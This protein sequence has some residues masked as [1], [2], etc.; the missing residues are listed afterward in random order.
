MW[1]IPNYVWVV[2]GLLILCIFFFTSTV[3]R[4][5]RR[6]GPH[7]ALL[8]Y[9]FRGTRVVKGGGTVVF[10]L[11]EECRCL[12]LEL[13]SFDVA[14]QQDLYTKQGVA[15]TV[16]AV[17]QIK[18]K[19]DPESI[20]TASE[21]FLTKTSEMRESLIRLVMEGHLRGIIGQ[22]T[23]EQIVKEPE[24]VA[25]RMRSTCADD[26][27]KM[28]LEVISF[29]IKEVR[30]KNEYISNMG[31]PDVARIK[32]DADVATA[33]AERDTAIKRAVAQ[34]ES[35]VAKAQADQERVL[36]ETL[37]LAKQAESERDLEIKRATYLEGVKRQQAQ[38]DKAYDIQ[39]NIMQQQLVVEQVKVQQVE[40]EHQI[41]VQEAEILRREKELI[42]TV[43][44]EAEIERQ[45]IETMANAEKQRLIMEA[46]GK[47][48]AVREQGG[49]EAEIILKKGEA[50]ARAM[51][52]KAEAFQE[53]NQA[54][55]IDK[56]LTGLPEIVRALAAPLANVDKITI[57]STGDGDSAGIHKLTADVTK[58]AAQAPALFEALSGVSVSEMFSKIRQIG[59]KAEKPD[60][61]NRNPKGSV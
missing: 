6:A 18:V 58:I 54:A 28:G 55:V 50:E 45:R 36:A 14:P 31:R 40:R 5:Y 13:M 17:A 26:M 48:A 29:A 61:Q 42:A 38:A 27:S 2:C 52:V 49:A 57:V 10:P 32:R 43:L 51:N 33:E 19:S 15:V 44:K 22:L 60:P 34:R 59:D 39:T 30:D 3:V 41:K 25:E 4:L 21:Q 53:Y 7:E 23:V 20:R 11:L 46:E 16:E 37:S 24:M 1:M 35:A 56:L 8:V 9:G 12:S 47:A